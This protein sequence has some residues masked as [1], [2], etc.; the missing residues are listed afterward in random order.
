MKADD[1]T[2]HL[3]LDSIQ[4]LRAVAALM[5]VI[6]H[7]AIA[8]TPDDRAK[9]LW[10]P[11]LSDH[12]SLGVALFF[13]ISGFIIA[14]VLDRPTF[15]FL[16]YIWRRAFRIVPLY[17]LVMAVALG[18]YWQRGWFRWDF[19][20]AGWW[21]LLKGFLIFPQK[22]L[23][24]YQPGWSL[25]HEVIFYI[26]AALVVPLAGLR[27]LAAFMFTLGVIG[28]LKIFAWDYHLFAEAQ[29]FFS[30]GILA[31][32]ARAQSWQLALP[33]AGLGFCLAYLNFYAA[34]SMPEPYPSICFAIGGAGLIVALLDFERRGIWM[35]KVMVKIGDASYSLYLWHWLV[36]PCLST[37]AYRY[38]DIIPEMWRWII[39]FVSI[40]IAIASHKLI[41]VPLIMF[42]HHSFR[43]LG[44]W[45]RPENR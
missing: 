4:V 44:E 37:L 25:E 14:N 35:P 36:I 24:F 9:L 27:F 38:G 15:N 12:G 2:P 13:V 18:L 32:L 20:T 30:F 31:Y 28:S 43:W 26:V 40:A 34:I 45:R 42:S 6:F 19:E 23:P 22:L 29:Y 10:W 21:G 8:F 1:P 3:K 16:S 7:S 33:I 17:W 5:V 41:E 39:V 11:G